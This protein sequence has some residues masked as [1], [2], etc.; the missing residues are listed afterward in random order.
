MSRSKIKPEELIFVE[1]YLSNNC[2]AEAAAAKAGRDSTSLIR[3]PNVMTM[4][5]DRL[6]YKAMSAGRAV[7]RLSEFATANIM[8]FITDEGLI[9]IKAARARGHLI[10]KIKIRKIH[11][12][13]RKVIGEE[14]E[15]ELHD[16]LLALDKVL[17]VL[18]LYRN[19]SITVEDNRQIINNNLKLSDCSVSDLLELKRIL[20]SKPPPTTP[21]PLPTITTTDEE[22]IS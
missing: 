6:K 10:K 14:H 7:A 5:E 12:Q 17:R 3:N 2:N 4:I 22:T 1:E 15:L 11:D 13:N 19:E 16:S 9:D 18:G 21:L 20:S 8:D